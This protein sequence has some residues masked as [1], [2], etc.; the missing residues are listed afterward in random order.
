MVKKSITRREVI[1][2]ALISAAWVVGLMAVFKWLPSLFNVSGG[3][4]EW[5]LLN[6]VP[7]TALMA[8]LAIVI[9]VVAEINYRT[10]A[11]L[12]RL[13]FQYSDPIDMAVKEKAIRMLIDQGQYEYVISKLA[14]KEVRKALVKRG[15]LIDYNALLELKREGYPIEKVLGKTRKTQKTRQ[16]KIKKEST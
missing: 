7:L 2:F 8:G 10:T 12:Y 5:F 11:D 1:E 4:Y 13:A 6:A 15:M 16:K 9:I 3:A 14:E